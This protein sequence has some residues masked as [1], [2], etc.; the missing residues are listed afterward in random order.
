MGTISLFSA[1]KRP[2]S[3]IQRLLLGAILVYIPVLN[4]FVIGYLMNC[5]KDHD[6]PVWKLGMFIK[7]LLSIL[8][9]LIYS[10]PVLLLLSIVSVL[11]IPFDSIFILPFLLLVIIT[12]FILPAA[13][14]NYFKTKRL[15]QGVFTRAF[16]SQYLVALVLGL[17]WAAIL[18][19]LSIAFLRILYFIFPLSVYFIISLLI[20]GILLF[21]SQISLITMLSEE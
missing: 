19:G 9:I 3:H 2:F 4:I 1:I 13:L 14:I 15:F 17:F 7:G 16:N 18:N 10:I 6:L 8:I 11:E 21:A 5:I 20:S 12:A